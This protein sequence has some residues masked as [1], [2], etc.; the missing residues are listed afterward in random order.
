MKKINIFYFK[1]KVI[2][3]DLFKNKMQVFEEEMIKYA[4]FIFVGKIVQRLQ[5][6]IKNITIVMNI[7]VQQSEIAKLNQ[8]QMD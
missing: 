5:K 1:K 8:Q 4:Y 6:N 2:T 3:T 7:L